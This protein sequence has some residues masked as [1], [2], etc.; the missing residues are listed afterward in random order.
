M[1]LRIKI[2]F[3]IIFSLLFNHLAG[4]ELVMNSSEI[5]IVSDNRNP[6]PIKIALK[7]LQ[8]DF[9]KVMNVNPSILSKVPNDGNPTIIIIN[10]ETDKKGNLLK[11]LDGFESHRVW[12]DDSKKTI[13]IAGADTRGTIYAIYTFSEKILGVPPLWYWSYWKPEQKSELRIPYNLDI[14]YKSPQVRYRTWFPNDTHLFNPWTQKNSENNEIWLETLLRLKLNTVET[15]NTIQFPSGP[16]PNTI[17]RQKYGVITTLHHMSTISSSLI[18]WKRYWTLTK[19]MTTVPEMLLSNEDELYSFWCFCAEQA[20]TNKLDILWNIAFRGDGDRPFWRTFK[21][22]PADDKSRGK[23]I[24]H[25]FKLQ[26]DI[27]KKYS[28]QKDPYVRIT[29]YD[30]LS[31][32]Y[33]MGYIE[34]P[35]SK[36]LILVF[37]NSRRNHF[38]NSDIQHYEHSDEIKIGY[39]FN[40]QFYDT[41]SH[42]VPGEGPWKGEFNFRY[43]NSKSPLALSVVNAGN[44]RE[45]LFELGSNAQMMWDF[46][47]YS[48]E[49]YS[50]DFAA[51]YFSKDLAD[52]IAQLYKDY[53]NAYWKPRKEDF[54]GGMDRQYIYGDLRFARTFIRLPPQFFGKYEPNP[55]PDLGNERVVGRSFSIV[56]EHNNADNQIDAILNG[57]SESIPK[58]EAVCIKADE[59]LMKIPQENREFFK[60]SIRAYSYYMKHLSVSYYNLCVAYKNQNSKDILMQNLELSI[61]ELKKARQAMLD[62]QTGVF[63]TWYDPDKEFPRFIKSL[64]DLKAK[65]QKRP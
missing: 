37:S 16:T 31:D 32:L 27:I 12:V 10:R 45:F 46:E 55:L 19:K 38:P 5:R 41:G 28:K 39:Y 54:P 61:S 34:L 33:E 1:N 50:S 26:M 44:L 13:F 52:D 20:I 22:A 53:Y 8:R 25:M 48:S 65:A 9:Q 21:D 51:Q 3:A 40:Y 49:K 64:E 29:L 4:K 59:L 6:E 60:N 36:N 14:F 63:S 24:S 58:F 30:E 47:N 42:Y 7:A 2:F 18:Q 17:L 35:K 23:V 57:M 11:P 56:P 62:T 43:A 15:E